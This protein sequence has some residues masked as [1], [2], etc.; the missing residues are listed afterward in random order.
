MT[1]P[2]L[3]ADALH[4]R[5]EELARIG[6]I[7]GG[8]VCRLALTDE[9]RAAR[10]QLVAWM[11]ELGLDVAIDPIGNI[12]GTRRGRS[13]SLPVTTGS[14]L[15]T[16]RTGGRYDGALGVMAGLEVVAALNREGIETE[17]PIAVAAFTNEEGARFVPDMMGSAVHQG[18]LPLDQALETVGTDGQSV[19]SELERIGYS[20]DMPVKD[21]VPRA[22]LELHIEQGPVLEESGT[23][24]GAVTGVQLSLIHI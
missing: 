7:E 9:D 23:T 24:I 1:G 6:A 10:D 11:R 19:G 13:D 17:R 20:G 18:S 5:L 16:V 12:V 8:G 3:D 21:L 4:R 15:D 22:Y 14:H 2:V